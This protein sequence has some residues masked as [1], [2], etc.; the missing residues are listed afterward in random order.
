MLS[1][2]FQNKKQKAKT[3]TKTNLQ[4]VSPTLIP[5]CITDQ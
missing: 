4:E 5:N 2:E 1:L 3:K